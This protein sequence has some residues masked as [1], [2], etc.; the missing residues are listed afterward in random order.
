MLDT[1]QVV[2]LTKGSMLVDDGAEEFPFLVRL[3]PEA[4]AGQQA[5]SMSMDAC[6]IY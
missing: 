1:R 5:G 2:M 4:G 6:L 3:L